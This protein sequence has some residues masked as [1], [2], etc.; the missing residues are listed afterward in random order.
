MRFGLIHHH[1]QGAQQVAPPSLWLSLSSPFPKQ[2][3]I[4]HPQVA[5]FGTVRR[6]LEAL[7]V[8]ST[9]KPAAQRFPSHRAGPHPSR[10]PNDG[11]EGSQITPMLRKGQGNPIAKW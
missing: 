4:T 5:A 6:Q 8:R 11:Y 10:Y 3:S 1:R 9:L 2:R 7:P